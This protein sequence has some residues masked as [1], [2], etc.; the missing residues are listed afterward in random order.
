MGEVCC[1]TILKELNQFPISL[2]D[3]YENFQDG[4]FSPVTD[5][6]HI[7]DGWSIE[8]IKYLWGQKL[9]VSAVIFHILLT[10]DVYTDNN[11]INIKKIKKLLKHFDDMCYNQF[12]DIYE[13]TDKD[14]NIY[15]RYI[16][17]LSDDDSYQFVYSALYLFHTSDILKTMYNDR[18]V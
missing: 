7:N 17:D 15:N 4:Y 10:C 13:I 5:C 11:Q 9:Y 18:L 2:D 16:K 12:K 1:V 3:L 8:Y 14:N 6:Y